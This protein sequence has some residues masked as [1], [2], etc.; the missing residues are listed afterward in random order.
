V[1]SLITAENLPQ[2][3]TAIGGLLGAGGLVTVI[4]IWRNPTPK[5]G[6]PDAA[7]V[8]LGENTRA[9]LAMIDA[10]KSQN[11]HFADNNEMFK[12]IGP[13][14]S[15]MRHDGA[16]SKAHLAAIRDALNRRK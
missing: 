14:L 9:T 13:V 5:P 11:T 7:M 8:A 3:L 2:V 10:M 12:A 1:L 16:D 4:R 6:T 15:D